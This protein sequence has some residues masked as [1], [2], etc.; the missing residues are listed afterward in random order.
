MLLIIIILV[1]LILGSGYG[2]YR[3]GPGWG[4]YGGGGLGLILLIV[5]IIL[6]LRGGLERIDRPIPQCS[7]GLQT[8]SSAGLP[9]RT[10]SRLVPKPRSRSTGSIP[11]ACR[12]DTTLRSD[13]CQISRF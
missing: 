10:C 9:P 4:Y 7:A 6:L 11:K 3:M 12:R 2:G 8:G 5:L 1:L 13:H